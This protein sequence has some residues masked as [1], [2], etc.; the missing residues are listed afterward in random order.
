MRGCAGQQPGTGKKGICRGLNINLKIGAARDMSV[1]TALLQAFMTMLI[2]TSCSETYFPEPE[3]QG[4]WRKNTDP[5]FLISLD[6][7]PKGVSN[8]LAYNLQVEDSTSAIVIKDGW[9]VG[10]WYAKKKKVAQ[11]KKIYVASVGKSIALACFGIAVKDGEDGRLPVNIN[12]FS[13][14]Y[15][16]RWIAEGFPLSDPRK[17]DITFEQVFRHTAG[18]AAEGA[19][20]REGRDQQA[21][22]TAWVVGHDP[23]YPQTRDLAY[24]PGEPEEYAEPEQWGEQLG[25]YSSLGFAHLSLMFSQLYEMPAEDFLWDRLLKKIGFSGIEFHNPP[26]PPAIKWFSGG[27][28]KMTTRDLA[29]FG[30]LMLHDGSWKGEQILPQG[31]VRSFVT[32]PYYPNLR[33]NVDGYLHDQFPKDLYRMYGSGG[34]F[35][36]VVPALDLIAIR[37][38]HSDN[39]FLERLQRDLVRRIFDMHISYRPL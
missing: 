21:D 2:V 23:Q 15:D 6:L 33:S 25:L 32:T 16:K 27:G 36:F 34:N 3:S 28:L 22:Y 8:F 10:E 31:W 39:F 18:F 1:R 14:L 12:R 13:K 11:D 19:V 37:T 38:G 29:R 24:S 26:S 7:N 17:R 9:I 30:Y 5:D 20:N 35:V 4:G